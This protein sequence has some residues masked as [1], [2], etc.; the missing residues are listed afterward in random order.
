[1]EEEAQTECSQYCNAWICLHHI[2]HVTHFLTTKRRSSSLVCLF[3]DFGA[4]LP[5]AVSP[6]LPPI[7]HSMASSPPPIHHLTVF[8]CSFV[9]CMRRLAFRGDVF[10]PRRAS[11]FLHSG[12]QLNPSSEILISVKRSACILHD[13]VHCGSREIVFVLFFCR[14][15]QIYTEV[16]LN[17]TSW[18]FPTV[19]INQT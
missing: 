12:I 8:R 2:T 19:M 14:I 17:G 6:F 4:R 5:P 11:R 18:V 16:T 15:R 1:M 9:L 13:H 3:G 7:R 10:R